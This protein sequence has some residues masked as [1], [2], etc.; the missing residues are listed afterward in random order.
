MLCIAAAFALAVNSFG[1]ADTLLTSEGFA[2]KPPGGTLQVA[3]TTVDLGNGLFETNIDAASYTNWVYYNFETG[4]EVSVADPA[5]DSIWDIALQRF[6]VKLNG[7]ASG[8]AGATVVALTADNFTARTQAPNPFAPELTDVLDARRRQRRLP[9]DDDRRALCFLAIDT[10]PQRLLVCLFS[11]SSHTARYGLR[12]ENGDTQILQDQDAELLWADRNFGQ[13]SLSMGRESPLR[14]SIRLRDRSDL[15]MRRLAMQKKLTYLLIM[16]L[17]CDTCA[18]AE[19]RS[20]SCP[21]PTQN[22][23]RK[24]CAIARW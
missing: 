12:G 3:T 16:S 18:G 11:R 13:D 15:N 2:G 14:N 6:V 5:S 17:N 8:N 20:P 4:Q 19:S 24:S 1:C 10:K 21:G 23:G 22:S 9:P 7:G